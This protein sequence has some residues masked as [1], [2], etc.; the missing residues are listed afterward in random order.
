METNLLEISTTV[1]VIN[2]DGIAATIYYS[3]DN[4]YIHLTPISEIIYINKA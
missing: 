4:T 2:P 1:H 3:D